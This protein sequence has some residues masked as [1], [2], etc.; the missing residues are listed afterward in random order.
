MDTKQ[1]E[2]KKEI[3]VKIHPNSFA[4]GGMRQ[5]FRMKKIDSSFTGKLKQA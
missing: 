3:T 5:C 1:W 2:N 4:K